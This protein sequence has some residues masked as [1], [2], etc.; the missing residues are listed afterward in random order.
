MV[1]AAKK[2]V[3]PAN[4]IDEL[5]ALQLI[6]TNE[7]GI[8]AVSKNLV[9]GAVRILDGRRGAL[10]L[11][12][13][14]YFRL[15]ASSSFSE[16][17]IYL[18]HGEEISEILKDALNKKEAIL[19]NFKP[20]TDDPNIKELHVDCAI[21]APISIYDEIEGVLYIDKPLKEGAFGD[22]ELSLLTIIA[23]QGSMIL[24]SA[25]L[26]SRLEEKQEELERIEKELKEGEKE[27]KFE[28]ELL[29]PSRFRYDYSN[30]VGVSIP[31]LE[32]FEVL[33]K[34]IDAEHPVLVQGE[35]GT[36]KEL[37]ARSI[38]FNGPRQDGPFVSVNCG[39]I[40][41]T[42]I[43]S[44]LF[45]FVKGAFTG[46][47]RDKPGL[48]K[49]AHKGTLFLDEIAE[50]PF[51]LQ[52][53]L[54]R[55]LQEKRFRPVGGE[56][57]ISVDVRIISATNKDLDQEVKDGLFRE[58]LY[59]RLNI[60]TLHVPPLRERVEDM[61]P[62]IYHLLRRVSGE[63]NKPLKPM[64]PEVVERLK[65]YNWPGNVRQLEN[66]I[67]KMF[68]LSGEKITME[69][70]NPEIMKEQKHIYKPKGEV[71]GGLSETMAQVE[72]DLIMRALREAD[73]NKTE[74]AKALG[75]NRSTLY[76]KLQK[77]RIRT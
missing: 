54:L 36:G 19:Y 7:K 74:A 52:T 65:G 6:I 30:I 68:A 69:D 70:L 50:L 29:P 64:S 38:H 32:L 2:G 53:K 3:E 10:F 26:T 15:I 40:A 75:I 45:G 56:D 18:E 73:G 49:M 1:L 44:E 51:E 41:P 24:D 76:E 47:D 13:G 60:I 12:E 43:E 23:Q 20:F 22:Y 62:L 28:E 11:K 37:I 9:E 57:E 21:A 5:L 72:S 25:W 14:D 55:V 61:E 31:M 67:R 77:L 48:F 8:D 33:D 34:V 63:E 39:A 16:A 27:Q 17:E 46:A 42:L 66:E 35:S 71:Q 58:D 4:I 59:Y